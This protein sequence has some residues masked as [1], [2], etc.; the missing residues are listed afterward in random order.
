MQSIRKG[1]LRL[2]EQASVTGLRPH[3]LRHNFA[4]MMQARGVSNSIIMSITGHKTHVM[5]HRYSHSDDAMRISA[6]EGLPEPVKVKA[7]SGSNCA[8]DLP[9]DDAEHLCRDASR[10]AAWHFAGH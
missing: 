5:L 10:K 6:V 8:V 3:D 9:N 7:R 1:W 4:S 2:C